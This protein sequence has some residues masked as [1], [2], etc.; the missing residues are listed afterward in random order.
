MTTN[1]AYLSTLFEIMR[2]ISVLLFILILF[3]P[4]LDR[5]V[6]AFSYFDEMVAIMALMFLF[7][8][9]F[10]FNGKKYRYEKRSFFCI[11]LVLIIGIISSCHFRIQT[12]FSG[13][14][15]DFL[16]ILKFP[17]IYYGFSI[18]SSSL[19]LEKINNGI[20]SFLKVFSTICLICGLIN[21]VHPISFFTNDYRYGLPSYK[22]IYPHVTFFVASIVLITMVLY[23]NGAKKNVVFIFMNLISLLLSLRSKPIAIIIFVLFTFYL[24]KL[25]RISRYRLIVYVLVGLLMVLYLTQGQFSNY[26]GYGL[27]SVRGALH[28]Y[29]LDV[30]KEFFPLGSGFCTFGS[31]LAYMYDSNLYDW[32][33][34]WNL[35]GMDDGRYAAD[36]FW[37]IIYAQFG[38]LGFI[39]YVWMLIYVFKAISNKYVVLSDKWIASIGLLIYA[40]AASCAES[41]FTNVTGALYPIVLTLYLGSPR[42]YSHNLYEN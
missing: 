11:V 4:I 23:A 1:Q 17:V 28:V 27:T 19:N 35:Q 22:F 37:P 5:I 39:C 31:S 3:A 34:I 2:Y 7:L 16:S 14:W 13:I 18:A 25:R 41:F 36:T 8:N 9:T 15:R 42:K 33:G 30:A 38:V 29:G 21:L 40:L 26:I 20:Q 24:K 12:N 6:P 32:Y 10:K